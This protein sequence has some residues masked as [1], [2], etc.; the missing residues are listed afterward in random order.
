MPRYSDKRRAALEA[1]MCAEVYRVA[2][3][4]IGR[5]GL[6]ALTLERIAR[7]VGV[8]RG[9]LY[10]YFADADAVL[11]FVEA[12]TFDP[13]A[14][15]ITAISIG[16]ATPETK[17]TEVATAVFDAL[18]EDRALAMALFAK[19][20]LSG[21]RADQK[22]EHRNHFIKHVD[23]IIEEGIERGSFRRVATG[24]TAEL[25]LGAMS[26]LIESMMY[27][28]EFKPAHELVPDLMDLVLSGLSTPR[29]NTG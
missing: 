28:G 9:T 13:I 26:G 7:E 27:A 8:S 10:N 1:T 5:E 25:F 16:D 4:I 14:E 20:E 21:P 17:L 2:T 24:I 22:I 12:R 6:P 19:R 18:Y 15:R 29:R 3:E 23:Q 11:N